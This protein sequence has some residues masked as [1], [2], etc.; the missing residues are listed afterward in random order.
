MRG[1]FRIIDNS[2]LNQFT[3]LIE[4]QCC[5]SREKVESTTKTEYKK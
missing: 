1:L 5:D 2:E 3:S 4:V